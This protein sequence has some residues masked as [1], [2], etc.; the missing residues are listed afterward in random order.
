MGMTEPAGVS[1]KQSSREHSISHVL[2]SFLKL[3]TEKALSSE[4]LRDGQE[5]CE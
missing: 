1:E 2:T 3:K 5:G 4:I